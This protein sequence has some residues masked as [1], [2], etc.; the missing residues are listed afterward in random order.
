MHGRLFCILTMA[1]L[2]AAAAGCRREPAAATGWGRLV[3]ER[4][5]PHPASLGE[6]RAHAQYC[7]RDSLL[8][9]VGTD[10]AWS[11]ALAMRT[12][13]PGER[14]FTVDT[15][16]A[17]IGTAAIAARLIND[18]VGIALL[19]RSGSIDLDAGV[20]LAG[21]FSVETGRDS[22]RITLSGRFGG[23]KP[24]TNGCASAAGG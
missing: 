12:V 21:H 23:M 24:D 7:S 6:L 5:A 11:A 20:L 19:S 18:S 10:D 17:G 2:A 8:S 15:L 14:H 13:W 22:T 9:I 16:P 3:L 1:I 4:T